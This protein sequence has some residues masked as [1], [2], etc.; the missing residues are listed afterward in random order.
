MDEVNTFLTYSS[1]WI[2]GRI[3]HYD[4]AQA[5]EVAKSRVEADVEKTLNS[6]KTVF[7]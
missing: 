6:F 5:T 2:N 7:Y 4:R 3:N 1:E